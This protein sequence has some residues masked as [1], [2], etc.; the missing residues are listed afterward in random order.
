MT[1][2]LVHSKNIVGNKV[3]E[4]IVRELPLYRVEKI[5]ADWWWNDKVSMHSLFCDGF[6]RMMDP[7][8]LNLTTVW[9]SSMDNFKKEVSK[10]SNKEMAFYYV[11]KVKA[12]TDTSFVLKESVDGIEKKEF[13]SVVGYMAFSKDKT[14][15]E[16]FSI[17]LCLTDVYEHSI[18]S[19]NIYSNVSDKL[20]ESFEKWENDTTYGKWMDIVDEV[21]TT[22]GIDLDD[23][24]ECD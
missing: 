11:V 1:K 7:K 17:E 3:I 20:I 13:M 24:K 19:Y 15:R 14:K 23:A 16:L 22:Y 5:K 8:L 2:N 6:V 12:G 10:E 18:Y 4:T 21:K 9:A